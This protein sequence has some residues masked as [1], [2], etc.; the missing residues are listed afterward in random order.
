MGRVKRYKVEGVSPYYARQTEGVLPVQQP[1]ELYYA[2]DR[3]ATFGLITG[4]LGLLS[5][6]FAAGVILAALVWG[7]W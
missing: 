6:G 3:E 2:K 7:V 4:I 5:F 1:V